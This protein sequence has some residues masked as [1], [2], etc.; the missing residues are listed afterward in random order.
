MQEIFMLDNPS[1]TSGII[2]EETRKIIQD[3][4]L[5]YIE[6]N[7][8]PEQL[9]T[10]LEYLKDIPQQWWKISVLLSLIWA[11]NILLLIDNISKEM[12][13]AIIIHSNL[14]G[15]QKVS[16]NYNDYEIIHTIKKYNYNNVHSEW[17]KHVLITAINE[18]KLPWFSYNII[19]TS[20][21]IK[22]FISGILEE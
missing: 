22:R 11:K 8:T 6:D 3:N 21:R 19:N 1:I 10:I 17:E 5:M 9:K 14:N 16:K 12:L 18:W 7:S 4:N 20:R 2:D 15:L 13:S